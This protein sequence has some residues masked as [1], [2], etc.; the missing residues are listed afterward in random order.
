M[1]CVVVYF[2]FQ[3]YECYIVLLIL[4][5]VGDPIV[6]YCA[7]RTYIKCR[8]FIHILLQCIT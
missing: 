5:I 7:L 4:D 3:Y 2:R 1:K 6:L 8:H